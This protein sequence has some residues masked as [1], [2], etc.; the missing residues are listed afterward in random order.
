MGVLFSEFHP[1]SNLQNML[2]HWTSTIK[3]LLHQLPRAFG[4]PFGHSG[5]PTKS[6][7]SRPSL[8]TGFFL[9]VGL[10]LVFSPGF[11]FT[12]NIIMGVWEDHVPF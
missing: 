6:N 2:R 12:W 4:A 3:T 1:F 9:R 7:L 11:F 5:G 8:F 10:A